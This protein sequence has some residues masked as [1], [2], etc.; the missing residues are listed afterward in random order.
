M[1]IRNDDLPSR[2]TLYLSGLLVEEWMFAA[3]EYQDYFTDENSSL[4]PWGFV[5][6]PDQWSC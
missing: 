3:F 2:F 6:Q 1:I 5:L 4:T